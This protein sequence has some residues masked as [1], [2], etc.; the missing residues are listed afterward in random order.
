MLTREYP[1]IPLTWQKI[2]PGNTISV[3]AEGVWKY[4]ELEIGYD[5]SDHTFVEGEVVVGVSSGAMGIV[6]SATV[7]SG[8]I[9]TDS[10]AGK[11]RFHSWNGI[12]FTNNEK[13]KVA[14]DADVGDI[15]GS[16]PLECT[17][18]YQFKEDIAKAVLVVA[19]TF[20]QRIAF[21][22]KKILTDQT[23]AVGIAVTAG[24]SILIS[25]AAAIKNLNVVD[26]TAGS[27]GSSVIVGLF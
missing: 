9:G 11:I 12:N 13:I 21:S 17:D 2:T 19:E 18:A 20:A 15:D 14:A 26:A 27:A 25:D 8:A 10:A 16:V 5:A 6:R 23:S 3:V 4:K 22:A 7:S 24:S 1:G